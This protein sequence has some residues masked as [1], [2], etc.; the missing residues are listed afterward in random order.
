MTC[1]MTCE[2]ASSRRRAREYR[3]CR[4]RRRHRRRRAR[5]P[6]AGD[7]GGDDERGA[8]FG[9]ARAR[10]THAQVTDAPDDAGDD[11]LR[12]VIEMTRTRRAAAAAWCRRHARVWETTGGDD[13]REAGIRDDAR[14]SDTR[15]R[16]KRA[17]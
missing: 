2:V 15:A 13:E 6:A 16:Y 9:M 7:N 11:M 17:Q 14:A 8:G 4:C 1:M 10:V 3:R 12:R 5:A